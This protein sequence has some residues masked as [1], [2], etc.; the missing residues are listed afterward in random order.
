[1]ADAAIADAARNGEGRPDVPEPVPAEPP[2][3]PGPVPAEPP[4]EPG[5]AARTSGTGPAAG[6][7]QGDDA[8]PDE[9]GG[10][11]P[12][13]PLAADL[14]LDPTRWSLWP[15][16]AILR[17]LLRESRGKRRG[18][19]YRSAPSLGFPA[20]EV[21]DVVVG[22]DGID[23]TLTSPGIASPGSPLP[24]SDIARIVADTYSPGR[25]AL[26]AWLDGPGDRFM[27]A[28]EAARS[29][30]SAAFSLA[31]GAT[32]MDALRQTACLVGR[33]AP[34]RADPGHRLDEGLWVEPEGAAGL[35][36]CFLGHPSARGLAEAAGAFTGLPVRVEE[37]SGARVRVMRPA[38]LGAPMMRMLGTHCTLST[39]GID[40]IVDGGT[41]ARARR[42]AKDP[43]RRRSLRLLCGRYVANR[44]ISAGLFLDL[45]SGNTEPAT[46]GESALGGMAVLGHP[47]T[48]VRLPLIG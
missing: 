27:Q 48:T 42:W 17:W 39:A 5:A 32:G 14:L 35:G 11:T 8:A 40:V 45:R 4:G 44:S 13:H 15:A 33:S 30:Y 18:L 3:E 41:D 19:M 26:A 20:S 9:A 22:T 16:V 7:A 23:L 38:R 21:R 2:G 43:V 6:E 31:T 47:S 12:S 34:L 37:F 10:A 36:A 25:G 24:T 28:L 29:R 1:M 46:L